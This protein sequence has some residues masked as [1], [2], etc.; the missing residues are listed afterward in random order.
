MYGIRE[1]QQ[2]VVVLPAG[3]WV[4]HHEGQFGAE[5]C[6]DSGLWVERKIKSFRIR[7]GHHGRTQ[8]ETTQ[9]GL[10]D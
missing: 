9:R 5:V 8:S 3:R 2:E 4:G 6:G 10:G 1:V 7:V